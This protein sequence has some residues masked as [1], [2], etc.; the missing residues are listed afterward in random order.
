MTKLPEDALPFGLIALGIGF[1]GFMTWFI[2]ASVQDSVR[3]GVICDAH[4]AVG[5]E[6]HRLVG[7]T[8]IGKYMCVD[9]STGEV[10]DPD[11]MK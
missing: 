2:Y 1:L 10:F 8:V 5:K 9:E 11:F 3:L 7:K 6:Y 4:H